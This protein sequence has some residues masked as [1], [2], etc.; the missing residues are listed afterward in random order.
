MA[1]R[2]A[3]PRPRRTRPTRR[4]SARRATRAAR[5]CRSRCRARAPR[6]AGPPGV[7]RAALAAARRRRAR[8]RRGGGRAAA[9][10]GAR[11]GRAELGARRRLTLTPSSACP[12]RAAA[13][14]ADSRFKQSRPLSSSMRAPRGGLRAP[15]RRGGPARA[16]PTT[17]AAVAAERGE[18]AVAAARKER[19]RLG[20]ALQTAPYACAGRGRPRGVGVRV[21]RGRDR[22]AD[23][24]GSRRRATRRSRRRSAGGGAARRSSS[25]LTSR[26]RSGPPNVSCHS[27]TCSA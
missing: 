9:G 15:A 18:L 12:R 5:R 1:E 13:G 4:A 14:G 16:R 23:R 22:V 6:H 26:T 24:A 19:V 21:V 20:A 17:S 8:A 11:R 27:R 7:R 2:R 25:L 10:V 3:R